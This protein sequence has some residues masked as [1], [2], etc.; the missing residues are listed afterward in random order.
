MLKIV[1]LGN[2]YDTQSMNLG[3]I[4]TRKGDVNKNCIVT[5]VN[6]VYY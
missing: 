1:L 3:L 5:V 6:T 2:C 4:C